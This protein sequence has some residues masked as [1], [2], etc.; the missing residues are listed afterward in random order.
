MGWDA[1]PVIGYAISLGQWVN[2]LLVQ[3]HNGLYSG[4][5]SD[6]ALVLVLSG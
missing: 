3:L 6:G 2:E 5:V 4:S 1:S